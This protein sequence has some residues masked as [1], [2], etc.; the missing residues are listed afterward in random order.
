MGAVSP[1]ADVVC[2]EDDLGSHGG[3][4]DGVDGVDGVEPATKGE[5]GVYMP[6]TDF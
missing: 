5:R 1:G 2:V 3:W 6:K 4:L